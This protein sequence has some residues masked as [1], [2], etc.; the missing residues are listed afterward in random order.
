MK[1]TNL[2]SLDDLIYTRDHQNIDS[3]IVYNNCLIVQNFGKYI[4][5]PKEKCFKINM[6]FTLGHTFKLLNSAVIIMS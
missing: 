2:L 1:P 3:Q 6:N 4:D 5:L